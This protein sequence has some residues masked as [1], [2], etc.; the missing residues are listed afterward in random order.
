MKKTYYL[1]K[2]NNLFYGKENSINGRILDIRYIDEKDL[3][4]LVEE[5]G[6]TTEAG[7]K[8]AYKKLIEEFKKQN[9]KIEHAQIDGIIIER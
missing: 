5:I 1:I 3:M 2:I 6:Y 4:Y 9:R 8:K 7:V